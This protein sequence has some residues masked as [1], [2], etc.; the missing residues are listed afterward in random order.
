MLEK[1]DKSKLGGLFLVRTISRGVISR[2]YFALMEVESFFLD[3]FSSLD[4]LDKEKKE[5]PILEKIALITI[6]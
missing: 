1:K 6:L 2:P 3:G 5:P 4:L